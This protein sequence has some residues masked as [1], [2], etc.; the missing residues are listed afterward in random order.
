MEIDYGILTA[1][2]KE[3]SHY[4]ASCEKSQLVKKGPVEYTIGEIHDKKVAM[5]PVGWGTTCTAAV[6]T[7]LIENFKPKGVFFSGTAGGIFSALNQGDIVIGAQ[8]FE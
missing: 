8:A 3:M 2:P 4:Y 7:H 5:V 1:V 6:M